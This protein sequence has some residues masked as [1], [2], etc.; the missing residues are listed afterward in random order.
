MCDRGPEA[1]H[2][3]NDIFD[4]MESVQIIAYH[5]I[6]WSGGCSLLFVS[7]DMYVVMITSSVCQP[8]Y[9]PWVPVISKDYRLI[10]CKQHVK[11][12]VAQA[13]R[14]FRLWLQ[15]HQVYHIYDAYLQRR[16]FF[17]Q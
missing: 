3:D 15:F 16:N 7:P 5:H 14:M 9:Q 12:A 13:M 11:V 8:V 10:F 1:R 17:P 6:E 4:Q 2:P